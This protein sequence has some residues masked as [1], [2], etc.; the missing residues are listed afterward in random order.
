MIAWKI[1]KSQVDP[2]I[3]KILGKFPSSGSA[4]HQSQV[5]KQQQNKSSPKSFGKSASV[6]TT[7]TLQNALSHCEC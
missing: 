3:A 7:P 4:D 6:V 2:Q 1:P 5:R